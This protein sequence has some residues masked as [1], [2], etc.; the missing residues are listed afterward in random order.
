[1]T[2]S[3]LDGDVVQGS[4]F[5]DLVLP[6]SNLIASGADGIAYAIDHFSRHRGLGLGSGH[7]R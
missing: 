7:L 1:M 6:Y 4:R 3:V 5:Q 2:G